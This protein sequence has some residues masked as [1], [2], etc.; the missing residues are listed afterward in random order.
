MTRQDTE[1][2]SIH[3]HVLTA[4]PVFDEVAVYYDGGSPV[5]GRSVR[6]AFDFSLARNV[7]DYRFPIYAERRLMQAADY[8]NS[9]ELAAIRYKQGEQS[10]TYERFLGDAGKFKRNLLKPARRLRWT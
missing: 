1:L 10:K 4:N 2:I 6:A 5:V 3:Q 8:L 7:T 9:I